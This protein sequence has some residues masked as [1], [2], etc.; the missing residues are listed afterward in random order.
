M[1]VKDFYGTTLTLEDTV[2]MLPSYKRGVITKLSEKEIIP[3]YIEKYLI[4]DHWLRVP[5]YAC[6]L[7]IK[8][9]N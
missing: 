5:P 8:G 9:G 3:G 1:A 4:L 2:V 7:Y 6:I